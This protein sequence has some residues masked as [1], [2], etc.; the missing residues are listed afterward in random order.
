MDDELDLSTADATTERYR[1][2]CTDCNKR[3]MCR[4]Y[5]WFDSLP[6]VGISICN[7]CELNRKAKVK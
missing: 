4:D 7:E 5:V 1:Q 3:R 6:G 2:T